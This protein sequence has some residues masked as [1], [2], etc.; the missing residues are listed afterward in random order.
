MANFLKNLLNKISLPASPSDSVVGIDIGASSIKAVQ[1]KREKGKA[2][3]E[4]Y[5][6]LALGPY[7]DGSV[8]GLTNLNSEVLAQALKDVFKEAQITARDAALSLP[9]ASSLVFILELPGNILEKDLK[10][11]VPIEAR[12]YIPTLLSEVALDWWLIPKRESFAAPASEGKGEIEKTKTEVLVAAIHNDALNK[13]KEVL[14][15]AGLSGGFFEIEAFSNIRSALGRDLSTVLIMDLGASKTKLSIVENGIMRKFHIIARGA[16]DITGNL[17]KALDI[18]FA[19]AEL[20]K[21]EF[22][23]LGIGTNKNVADISALVIDYIFAEVNDVL[24]AYEQKSG[25]T[26]NKVILTGGGALLKGVFD[27]ARENFKVE[28]VT[29]DPFGKAEA[30]EFL[31]KVLQSVGPPFSVAIGLA[32]KKIG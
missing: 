32:L 17:S 24:L 4:T 18:P 14:D 20:L 29:A 21:K 10:E 28:V 12:R 5:G 23:L 22:G 7:A 1:L 11:V 25:K 6:E 9:A 8:G 19:R 2:V 31:R 3:L 26:V 16:A 13:Y 27:R 15:K 30:P